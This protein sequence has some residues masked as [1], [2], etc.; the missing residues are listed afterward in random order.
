[1]ESE[2]MLDGDVHAF[3]VETATFETHLPQLLKDHP[4]EYVVVFG[5][6][7]LGFGATWDEAFRL[8]L[9]Q[10]GHANF[11]VRRVQPVRDHRLGA[12]TTMRW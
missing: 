10:I 7:V 2:R 11:V 4:N 5:A 12:F 8:G 6:S 1:M 9:D 3:D